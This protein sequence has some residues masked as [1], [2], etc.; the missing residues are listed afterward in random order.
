MALGDL[1]KE[2]GAGIRG[3]GEGV[4][5]GL[6]RYPAARA[7]QATRFAT[8]G[9]SIPY[10]EA[11]RIVREQEAQAEQETPV[12][13]YGGRLVGTLLGS[14]GA[15]VG[16]TL[17][18]TLLSAAGRGAVQ[19]GVSGFTSQEGMEDVAKQVGL[20]ALTGG[21]L[22]G[23][24]AGLSRSVAGMAVNATKKELDAT[25]RA[26]AER[27]NQIPDVQKQAL[28]AKLGDLV[29]KGGIKSKEGALERLHMSLSGSKVGK[30]LPKKQ[31][32]QFFEIRDEYASIIPD[33]YKA[34]A[35]PRAI[36]TMQTD[37]Q[38]G[39]N[40]AKKVLPTSLKES[41]IST[42]KDILTTSV[43]GAIGGAGLGA[44]YGALSPDQTV[45]QGALL[46][47][48]AGGLWEAKTK[49]GA[50]LPKAA[51]AAGS[52]LPTA[53]G[54]AAGRLATRAIVPTLVETPKTGKPIEI[55]PA[56]ITDEQLRMLNE[57]FDALPESDA[58]T[59][60]KPAATKSPAAKPSKF[61]YSNE[62]GVP[63]ELLQGVHRTES[64]FG[65]KMKSKAGAEGHFQFM[66]ATAK[67]YGLKDPYDFEQSKQAAARKLS[68][69]HKQYGNWE[70]ALQ[71]YNAGQGTLKKVAAG[72]KPMPKETLG[73]VAKVK[74][75][76]ADELKKINDEFDAL[77]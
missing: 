32:E 73:Y 24:G 34:F 3:V 58:S 39:L 17:G 30:S 42:A 67:E 66:P 15:P 22:S 14:G 68:D 55:A 31:R 60:S 65:T 72:Q 12:A 43:P 56:G 18:R 49:L 70:E 71:A 74:G 47:A 59:V 45:T 19:G 61:D 20:G 57:E 54:E 29:G 40:A 37:V 6:T 9:E 25:A 33:A 1:L 76:S 8:E 5:I 21:V 4:S 23:A 36:Q 48:G 2:L 64:A 28:D 27:L 38:K 7:L 26:A 62:Y 52:L 11:L 75:Y 16:Q 50:L 46:G 77:P 53:T 10:E 13:T 44:A 69:L 51:I 35:A 63:P 41:T